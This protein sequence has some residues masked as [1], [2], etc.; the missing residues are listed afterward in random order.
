MKINRKMKT[1]KWFKFGGDVEFLLRRFPFSELNSIEKVGKL[2]ADQFCY[3]VAD[4]KNIL[5]E[6]GE[7]L[8]CN[9]ENKLYLYDYYTDIRNFV[10]ESMKSMEEEEVNSKKN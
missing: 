8:I 4:W 6:D 3:C 2:M 7:L 1:E 9:D 5:D 10:L